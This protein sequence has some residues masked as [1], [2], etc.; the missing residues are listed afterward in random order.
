MTST[1]A[2]VKHELEPLRATSDWSGD[3]Y[4]DRWARKSLWSYVEFRDLSIA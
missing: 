4:N 2:N 1:M 3:C